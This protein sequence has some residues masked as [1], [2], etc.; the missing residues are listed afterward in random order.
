[1][2]FDV[3]TAERSAFERDFDVCVI[4]AGP[5]GITLARRLAA[6]GLEVALMEGG[7]LEWS[8][9]S[10]DVSAGESVGLA[11]PDLDVARLRYFGGSSG[12]WNGLCRA[13]EAADLAAAAAEPLERLADQQGRPR[14]L[15]GGGRRDPRPGP[16]LR[17]RPARDPCPAR[18][19]LPPGLVLAQRPDPVRR[20]VSRRDRERGADRARDPCEPRRPAARRHADARHRGGLPRLRRR[21]SRLHRPGAQLLPLHRR[22]GES[23]APAQLPQPDP[24]RHRQP[25]RPGGPVLLRSPANAG[26][27]GDLQRGPGRRGPVL[28]PHRGD[29]S[30]STGR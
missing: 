17:R 13:F 28:H 5:A 16:G 22:P 3:E 9:E 20:E 2:I 14:S 7:G 27:R 19:R 18:G 15:P 24:G 1:M 21:R 29:S 11:Y 23:A 12:H 30:P 10:Q 26:R 8:E 6:R 4:G 25:E